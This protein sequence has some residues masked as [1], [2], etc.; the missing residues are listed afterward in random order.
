MAPNLLDLFC[1][2]PPGLEQL[3]EAELR[4]LGLAGRAVPGGVQ[5]Q[6]TLEVAA[7]C[8]LWL[9]TASR[10]LV[11]L[12]SIEATSFPELVKKAQ[13]LPFE[14]CL[15]RGPGALPVALRVTCKKSRLYHSDAVAERLHTAM[16]AK[17]GGPVPLVA[18]A[19]ENDEAPAQQLILARF[20]HDVCTVSADASGT[21]LHRRGWRARGGKAPLRET[22]AAALVRASGFR[23]AASGGPLIDPLCGS[24]TIAIEA[25]LLARRRAPGLSRAF[26]LEHWQG[27]DKE[28]WKKL[29]D[30][31]RAQE[32]P[33]SPVAIVGSDLDPSAIAVARQNAE[34]AG[35]SAD[36]EFVE[37]PLALLAPPEGPG[38]VVT[39][40]PYGVRIGKGDDLRKL[41]RELGEVARARLRGWQITVLAG[42][43]LEPRE[44]GLRWERVLKTQNGGLPVV[45]LAAKA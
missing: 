30:E 45:A 1:V 28:N 19:G 43:D 2:C 22:L 38:F 9:R 37:R 34:A 16:Q 40:A 36:V 42:S 10:V 21:L 24:G 14:L 20:D 41:F 31:A 5:L 11:R 27:F 4:E 6:G 33:E 23:G 17:L 35:V 44:A 13:A 3:L 26:S 15:R 25:A 7:R 29:L 12:G 18:P 8:N 39:N 32:L